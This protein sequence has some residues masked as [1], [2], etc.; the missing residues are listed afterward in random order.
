MKSKLSSM[1]V[2]RRPSLQLQKTKSLFEFGSSQF[3]SFAGPQAHHIADKKSF[4]D[5]KNPV[6]ILSWNQGNHNLG[7]LWIQTDHN[8]DHNFV[9]SIKIVLSFSMW[10]CVVM[11]S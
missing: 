10:S 3:M 11:V 1:V 9:R 6:S 2:S 7:H 8:L 4:I 5:S